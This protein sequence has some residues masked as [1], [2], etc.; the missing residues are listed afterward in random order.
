VCREVAHQ[1]VTG[2][3]GIELK[4]AQKKSWPVFLVQIGK[5]SLLNLGHSKVEVAV[6]E[7]VKLVNLEN[8]KHDP[9][10]LVGKKMSHCNMKAYEHE[11]SPYDELFKGT[12]T[13]EEVLERVQTLSSDLQYS[14]QT[15]Q[16]HRRSGLPKV[17]QGET[18]TPPWEQEYT[19]PG[20]G[21]ET[22]GKVNPEEF[23]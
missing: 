18:I 17:L 19:P 4:S 6:L 13:Y 7:E 11:K 2:G 20:F 10:Q 22:Q 21:Q 15:F 16:K 5:F 1:I 8:R 12:K 23:P 9:Y 3:I 14:F